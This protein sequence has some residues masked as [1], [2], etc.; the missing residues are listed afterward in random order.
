MRLRHE[1]IH[2]LNITN[3][4]F[5]KSIKTT[6][7]VLLSTLLLTLPG[8]SQSFS[9]VKI[10]KPST[11]NHSEFGASYF[12]DGIIYCS[13]VKTSF[14]ISK[15]NTEDSSFYN[16]CFYSLSKDRT[17]GDFKVLDTIINKNF[18]NGPISSSGNLIAFARNFEMPT[19]SKK[20]I[21]NV[22]IFF[23]RKDGPT[24]SAPFPFPYNNES[25]NMG[26]PSLSSDGNTLYFSSDIPGGSGSY[27]IY[28]SQFK[29]GKWTA[30]VNLGTKINTS[31]SEVF[32]FIHSSGRLYFSTNFYSPEKK[33]DI[34][35]SDYTEGYWSKPT[36]LGE[37]I[38]TKYN[39][40]A[41]I[42][43]NSMENGF[44]ASDRNGN[45]DIFQFFSLLP[46]FEK[47]N[48]ITKRNYCYHFEEEKTI[49]TDTLPG[50][51]EWAFSDSTKIRSK[52]ADYCF[53]GAGF[54]SVDLN[55]IDTVSGEFIQM[56]ATYDIL[57]EDP[58]EPYIIC[59]DVIKTGQIVEFD[60]SQSNLP[61]K[62]IEQYI[63]I[64]S[65]SQKLVGSKVS[66]SFDIPGKYTVKLGITYDKD[67]SGNVQKN[68]VYKDF[69]VK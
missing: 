11:R 49:N 41:F 67:K 34:Y 60:G 63:W 3:T 48:P 19:S 29:N 24:W 28:K 10:I 15:Q 16:I 17:N 9:D 35:Y 45:D 23:C 44:F 68:C 54:Y 59:P 21:A 14:L 27:D 13:N 65:D 31:G 4:R 56:M 7:I 22:G 8:L 20:P 36:R 39:D 5:L 52:Q 38:N 46:T 6:L 66:R 1:P 2:K 32:P 33:S 69:L 42:C 61:G 50:I 12:E 57:I 18:N 47:C 30:P 43:D 26:H 51:Y 64:F 58:V 40:F 53:S 55:M 37:P 62:R 25:Y